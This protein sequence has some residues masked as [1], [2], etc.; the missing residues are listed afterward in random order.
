MIGVGIVC[1]KL[2]YINKLGNVNAGEKEK[3]EGEFF[4]FYFP[5]FSNSGMTSVKIPE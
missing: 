5:L 2:H 1:H 4:V 3:S